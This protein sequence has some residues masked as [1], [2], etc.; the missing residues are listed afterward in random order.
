MLVTL[1]Q[2]IKAVLEEIPATRES[3]KELA[4]EVWSRFYRVNPYAPMVDVMRNNRIPSVESMGRI[5]RKLQEHDES[6]RGKKRERIRI[7]AQKDYIEYA[8]SD[9]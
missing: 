8:K 4:I 9:T 6:L 3:D 5:R 1:E 7:N 2:K